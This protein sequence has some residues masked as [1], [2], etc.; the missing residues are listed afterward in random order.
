MRIQLHLPLSRTLEGRERY[1]GFIEQAANYL[2]RGWTIKLKPIQSGRNWTF[3][4]TVETDER[5]NIIE[6]KHAQG[7]ND[8][9]S[10]RLRR[11]G[12]QEV[13]FMS[14][15]RAE[16]LE[17]WFE[18]ATDSSDEDVRDFLE[19]N[20][21]PHIRVTMFG[22][23][24]AASRPISPPRQPAEITPATSAY[25]GLS[26]EALMRA[27]K[28]LIQKLASFTV[29]PE[30]I[31]DA[32]AW[33]DVVSSGINAE[34]SGFAALGP[35]AEK[36]R[37]KAG[38]QTT[39]TR[40]E[41]D[42]PAQHKTHNLRGEFIPLNER[43]ITYNYPAINTVY[44]TYNRLKERCRNIEARLAQSAPGEYERENL[45]E[46]AHYL[47]WLLQNETRLARRYGEQAV[48]T[49]PVLGFA[50]EKI[51]KSLEIEPFEVS[52]GSTWLPPWTR[53][54]DYVMPSAEIRAQRIFVNLREDQQDGLDATWI[55][56]SNR[57]NYRA[58]TFRLRWLMQFGRLEAEWTDIRQDQFKFLVDM[59]QILEKR[60]E[61]GNEAQPEQEITLPE[62]LKNNRYRDASLED[63]I[64]ACKEVPDEQTTPMT[65]EEHLPELAAWLAY[66][67]ELSPPDRAARYGQ[68]QT[69]L[70][71]ETMEIIRS[72]LEK[73][74]PTTVS[75]ANP[76]VFQDGQW[77][78][79]S[80]REPYRQ[81][82]NNPFA[83]ANIDVMK[84]VCEATKAALETGEPLDTANLVATMGLGRRLRFLL[85]NERHNEPIFAET[86]EA[87]ER[88]I[89]L[90]YLA[91]TDYETFSVP[92][93][94]DI[95]EQCMQLIR[96]NDDDVSIVIWYDIKNIAA[97]I[98]T[99]LDQALPEAVEYRNRLEAALTK[100]KYFLTQ[101]T[102]ILMPIS[103]FGDLILSDLLD[104][105]RSDLETIKPNR[106]ER[107][108][109]THYLTSL[110]RPG[111][112][113]TIFE[114]DIQGS[115][116]AQEARRVFRQALAELAA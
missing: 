7:Q 43:G 84:R 106:P 86:L 59:L 41:E 98:E 6:A 114:E 71:S 34:T 57:D 85:T 52:E 104:I 113:E 96:A 88:R 27:G 105:C 76:E 64:A 79:P 72:R 87:I 50:L 92:R 14:G 103:R 42:T 47:R 108:N 21:H 80:E 9:L 94:A 22:Q 81:P 101:P 3:R 61:I 83:K 18:R 74:A 37:N 111:V 54:V 56:K 8:A 77:I 107:E 45:T 40:T 12:V 35:R 29:P 68:I 15:A 55:V 60:L 70:F 2:R 75:A 10:D 49:H 26:A 93:L 11:L 102:T 65:S 1:Q 16:D 100:F 78:P 58:M 112:T 20:I 53:Q 24:S 63:I 32:Q 89:I 46:L 66:V 69:G 91:R 30:V 5:T 4:I 48:P 28:Q 97:R 23:Q 25:E 13:V 36:I 67:I 116:E 39:S 82:D 110:L 31:A 44:T 38:L 73:P 51:E 95:A 90:P 109:L 19:N 62:E 17:H 115:E 99:L 33:Y